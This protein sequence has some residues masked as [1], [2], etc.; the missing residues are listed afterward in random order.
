VN[1]NIIE[2]VSQ[3]A[4]P[5]CGSRELAYNDY[6]GLTCND[7]GHHSV[8]AEAYIYGLRLAAAKKQ[9]GGV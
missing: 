7:C 5:S 1:S 2:R 9:R 4:C 3:S 6:A 8:L